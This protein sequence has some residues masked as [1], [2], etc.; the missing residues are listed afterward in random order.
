MTTDTAHVRD[1]MTPSPGTLRVSDS[2]AVAVDVLRL[3]RVHHLPVIDEA[4]RVVGMISDRDVAG[5]A[6]LRA[7]GIDAATERRLIG[8]IKV[9]EVMAKTV[10]ST[11]PETSIR[12]AAA[13]MQRRMLRCL[14]VVEGDTLVG[15]LSE[16]DFVTALVAPKLEPSAGAPHPPTAA[17]E[18]ISDS[19]WQSLEEEFDQLRGIRDGLRVQLQLATMEARDVFREA[20]HRWAEL[21]RQL[22]SEPR[23]HSLEDTARIGRNFGKEISLIYEDLRRKLEA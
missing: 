17:K 5:G 4:K 8:R 1:L 19:G 20:E 13:L 14:P 11:T 10:E 12:E 22:A 18:P 2:L 21:E 3:G 15:I 23:D 16:R 9:S 7:A 6:V